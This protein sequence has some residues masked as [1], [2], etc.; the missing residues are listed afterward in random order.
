MM[1]RLTREHLVERLVWAGESKSPEHRRR[2]SPAISTRRISSWDVF[3]ALY[4]NASAIFRD[5]PET[6]PAH[7]SILSDLRAKVV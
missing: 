3:D 7:A 6:G 5:K 2:K 4:P 1:T